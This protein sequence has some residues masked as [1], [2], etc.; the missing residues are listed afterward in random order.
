M[1][2]SRQCAYEGYMGDCSINSEISKLWKEKGLSPCESEW[3]I[4]GKLDEYDK[5]K[6]E[7]EK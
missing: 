1:C 3:A 4:E 5:I 6:E 7:I 2:Y